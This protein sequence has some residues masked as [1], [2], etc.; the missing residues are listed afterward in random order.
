MYA[1]CAGAAAA[2]LG[3]AALRGPI[4]RHAVPADQGMRSGCPTCAAPIGHPLRGRCRSCPTRLGPPALVLELVAALLGAGFAA[5]IGLRPE[6]VGFL[7]LAIGGVALA[8]IDLMVCRLPDRFVGPTLA[9]VL[10]SFVAGA[11][12]RHDA[13]ALISAVAG[14]LALG[15]C[16][17][18]LGVLGA[19][20]LGLGDVKLAVLLGLALGWFG[21][22]AV[23]L[24]TCL[25]F[26]LSALVTLVLLAARRITLKTEVPFGPFMLIAAAAVAVAAA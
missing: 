18:A 5:V 24:G 3:A 16:Y 9:V 8:A 13:G 12:V 26:V 22:R 14:A 17:F 4:L 7:A 25:A 6:L 2:A 20:R 11:I 1:I 10:A 21:W 23:L 19:G 15:A